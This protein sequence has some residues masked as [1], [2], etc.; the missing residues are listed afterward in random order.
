MCEFHYSNGNSFGDIWWTDKLIYFRS[1]DGT[2]LITLIFRN[3]L[4]EVVLWLGC[5]LCKQREE[6]TS[7]VKLELS[8]SRLIEVVR[9]NHLKRRTEIGCL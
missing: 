7:H 6:I 8:S 3:S 4:F 5:V 1:I 9:K 2:T